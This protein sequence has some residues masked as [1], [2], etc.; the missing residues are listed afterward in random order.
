RAWPGEPPMTQPA[1]KMMSVTVPSSARA[2]DGPVSSASASSAAQRADNTF[3]KNLRAMGRIESHP[4][5]AEPRL[6]EKCCMSRRF[7][8]KLGRTHAQRRNHLMAIKHF[9]PP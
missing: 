3:I 2:G 5:L 7:D 9:P 8:G 4:N 6:P 1:L